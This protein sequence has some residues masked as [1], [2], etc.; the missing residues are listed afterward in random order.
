MSD[1]KMANFRDFYP[2]EIW[3]I[4]IRFSAQSSAVADFYPHDGSD[5]KKK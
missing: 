5:L 3:A 2:H 4:F 1:P